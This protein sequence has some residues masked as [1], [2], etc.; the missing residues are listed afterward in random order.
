MKRIIKKLIRRP[1]TVFIFIWT[2]VFC[3]LPDKTYLTILYRLCM[4]RSIDWNNPQTYTEKIQWLKIN[5]RKPFYSKLVDKYEVKRIVSE[6]IGDAHIIPTFG[7]YD[8]AEDIDFEQL[9]N[10]FVL[11]CTHDSGGIIVCK[12]KSLLNKKEV[13]KKLNNSL[14][15]NYFH[16]YKEWPYKDVTPRIIAEQYINNDEDNDDLKDYKFFC[17]NGSPKVLFIASDRNKIGEETKF[18][19]FDTDFKFLPFT[20]GHPNSKQ[21][22]EKPKN[23]DKMLEISA[24]LSVN[25]PHI[26]VDLYNLNGQIYFGELTFYHW[27]GIVPFNPEIWDYKLGEMLDLNIES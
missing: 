12:N 10:Q 14:K 1:S 25:F 26:R 2:R 27:S 3:W 7:V 19:F 8:N 13:I 4:G 15:R 9:P 11:K 21:V 17:F 16:R 22:I 18:D 23:F 24:K 6:I 20:N 5:D